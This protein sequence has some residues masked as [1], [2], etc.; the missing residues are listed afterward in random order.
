MTEETKHIYLFCAFGGVEKYTPMYDEVRSIPPG[1]YYDVT[2]YG[3]GRVSDIKGK[4]FVFDCEKVKTEVD[5]KKL[6]SYDLLNAGPGKFIFINDLIM[7]CLKHL[8]NKDIQ[9]IPAKIYTKN[10]IVEG[11][12][13]I[14]IVNTVHG[15][16]KERSTYSKFTGYLDKL[17]P[18][19]EDFMEGHEL[20]R[21]DELNGKIYIIP[22]LREKIL[23][24]KKGKLKGLEILTT[25]EY[26]DGG[27][28]T[29]KWPY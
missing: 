29:E 17:V 25:K 16:D 18:K 23:K 6:R 12:H 13:L 24:A 9:L 21:E 20:A 27:H 10:R 14:D 26:W 7:D 1:G 8:I 22:A 4:H 3:H 15:V 2:D 5:E 11:Y 19:N 28:N